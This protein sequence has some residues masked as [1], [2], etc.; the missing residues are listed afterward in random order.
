MGIS[1]FLAGGFSRLSQNNQDDPHLKA[2][3]GAAGAAF[4]FVFTAGFG[5]TWLTVPWLYP[6]EIFPLQVRAKGNA[7]G[8]VGW[9][10]GNGWTVLLLPTMFKNISEKTFYVFGACNAIS[11]PIV[12]A[13][14]PESNQRTLEEMDLLFADNSWFTWDAERTFARLKEENPDLVQAAQRHQSVVSGNMDAL[15]K[16]RQPSRGMSLPGQKGSPDGSDTNEKA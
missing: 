5:A 2:A 11:I 14:Y 6:A 13:F 8:V 16:G 9:S 1:M 10:I 15:E 12:W 3:Y 7:W 4:T